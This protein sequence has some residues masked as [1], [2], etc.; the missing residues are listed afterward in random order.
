MEP[1]NG[2]TAIQVDIK[3]DGLTYNIIEE[4]FARTKKA[5]DYILDEI[6]LKQISEPRKELSKYAPKIIKTKIGTD[7]I[8]DVIGPGGKMINKIIDETGVKIDIEED[9]NVF[10]Y[11]SEQEDGERAL[12]MID[13]IAREIEV[14]RNI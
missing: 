14:N 9:G 3:I 13:E 8:K 5:R 10:I 7:K 11:C 4:A 2:I 1:I 6:M 12:E